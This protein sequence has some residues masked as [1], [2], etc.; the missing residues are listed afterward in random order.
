MISHVA[1]WTPN[2]ERLRAFYERYFH[3]ESGPL[4]RS[5]RRPFSSY[6]LR[7]RT[8]AAL[9]LM[10]SPEVAEGAGGEERLGWAHIAVSLGSA[11]EVDR[12]TARLR[13]E[14]IRVVSEPRWTGDGFY[15][16]VVADPDGNRI[17]LTI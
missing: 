2:I 8:G 6:F 5:A 12:L 13:G 3:V 9:E 1:I 7:F 14:G 15:E 11:E 17:E 16:S 4:Y 10:Q